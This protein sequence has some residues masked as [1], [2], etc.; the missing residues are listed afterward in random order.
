MAEITWDQTGERY[1][2]T[3]VDR[4]VLYSPRHPV[5]IG[6]TTYPKGFAWNGLVSVDIKQENKTVNPI[7]YDGVKTLDLINPGEFSATLKAFTYPDEFIGYDGFLEFEEGISVDSQ[8]RDTFSLSYRTKVGSDVDTELGY[9]IHV[10]YNITAVADDTSTKTTD[11][12]ISPILFS[13]DIN[14]VPIFTG[15]RPA[16]HIVIDSTKIDGDIFAQIES[17]LYG[18]ELNDA[19]LPS[20][21]ELLSYNGIIIVNQGNGEWT[22][23][24][25]DEMVYLSDPDTFEIDS[26]KAVYL[27]ADTYEFEN[28]W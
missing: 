22:A 15:R 11:S 20:I 14:S 5:T 27:D 23:Y 8:N 13:W 2:E 24:G 3:G 1:F 9:K 16:S 4:G 12:N 25:P 28:T 19:R 18:S 6:D 10:I 26:D 17:V 21:A 7:Y